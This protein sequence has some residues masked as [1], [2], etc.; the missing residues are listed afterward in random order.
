MI[1]GAIERTNME[2]PQEY[3]NVMLTYIGTVYVPD[4]YY[5]T[6]VKQRVTR[7]AFYSKSNG[8]YNRQDQWIETPEGY[9]SVPQYWQNFTFSDGTSALLPHTFSSYGRVLP[10]DVLKWE[11]EK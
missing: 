3:Q 1:N 2:T 4:K 11:I 10:K 8:Y 9:F 7:R 6:Y 5:G